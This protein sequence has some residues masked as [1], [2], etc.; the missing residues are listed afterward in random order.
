[1]LRRPCGARSC[2]SEASPT[3]GWVGGVEVD[4]PGWGCLS[5]G[6]WR[7]ARAAFEAALRRE[8]TPESFEGLAW[9]CFW[10]VDVEG[11][12]RA[13]AEAYRSFHVRGDRYGAARAAMWI[14]SEH[15]EFKGNISIANGWFRRA[16]RLL[17]TA[18]P[19]PEHGWLAL[20]EGEGALFG[21]HDTTQAKELGA[22]AAELGRR[23]AS[24]ELEAVGMALEGLALVTEGR[25]N[26][27]MPLLDEA[28]AAAL[29]GSFQE[30]WA[31]AWCSCYVIYACERAHD[32]D[33]AAQW[34]REVE[35]VSSRTGID[36]VWALC[37]AHHAGVLVWQGEWRDAEAELRAAECELGHQRPPWMAEATVRLAEL[38]RRQGRRSEAIELFK[39]VEGHMLATQGMAEIALDQGDAA[40][41]RRLAEQLL[42]NI[43]ATARTQRAPGLH[44]LARSQA[45]LGNAEAAAEALA[46]L[47]ALVAS[48]GT[49]PPARR[50]VALCRF[51][52]RGPRRFRGGKAPPRG[53]G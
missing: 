43:P 22:A 53:R 12:F 20:H 7:E 26:E 44:L 9:S 11:L 6:A 4:D 8:A 48:V 25:V 23:C 15:L 32:F 33:R 37:R 35:E 21:R 42:R 5:R 49:L 36:F 29:G 24:P 17:A 30:L 52:Q 39:Q 31:I 45:A 41:A 3:V 16:R 51:G 2:S 38:R 28:A 19:S 14:G 40:R 10:L 18:D 1:M 46:E 13:R 47:E 50:C 34:C 27:G